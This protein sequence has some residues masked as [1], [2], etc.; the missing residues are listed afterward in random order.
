[1][2]RKEILEN[3][4]RLISEDRNVTHGNPH[5]QFALAQRLKICVGENT[6]RWWG[7][8]SVEREAIEMILTKIS[9]RIYGSMNTDHFADIAGY[10]GIAAEVAEQSVNIPVVR[11]AAHIPKKEP[12]KFWDEQRKPPRGKVAVMRNGKVYYRKK[13]R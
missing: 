6:T 3:V 11:M 7:L 4:A 10:A 1:M 12:L 13:P 9:R 8:T 5:E 2:N